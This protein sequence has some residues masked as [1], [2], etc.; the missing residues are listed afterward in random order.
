MG[1]K[2]RVWMRLGLIMFCEQKKQKSHGY[3]IL[4]LS[5]Y[6]ALL[7][8]VL[9]LAADLLFGFT[10]SR[11][12]IEVSSE[13]Q[14]NLRF[15]SEEISRSIEQAKAIGSI[16]GS[17]LTLTMP[18]TTSDPISFRL[19]NYVLEISKAG[20][21][22]APLTTQP[23]KVTNLNFGAIANST[24]RSV[25]VKITIESQNKSQSNQFTTVL[26]GK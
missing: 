5:I 8:V 22:F 23:V 20:S 6:M 21:A 24:V 4:E 15:A 17:N 7:V 16:S 26:R 1:K 19:N 14:Q 3:S 10:R 18:D 12:K 11:V 25:Q 9:T 2:R 13:I